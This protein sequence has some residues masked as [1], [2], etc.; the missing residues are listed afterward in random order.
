MNIEGGDNIVRDL[1][2]LINNT[3]TFINSNSTDK[4]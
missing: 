3:N 2:L 4:I 1:T